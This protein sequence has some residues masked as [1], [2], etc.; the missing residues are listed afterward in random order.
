MLSIPTDNPEAAAVHDHDEALAQV[1]RAGRRRDNDASRQ[2]GDPGDDKVMYRS[3]F[4]A[5]RERLKGP[6]GEIRSV[7]S[8]R[9]ARLCWVS[10]RV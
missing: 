6:F 1:G 3:T 10:I 8:R 2:L 4:A 9:G 7:I 5:M